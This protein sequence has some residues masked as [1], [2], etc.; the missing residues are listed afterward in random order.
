MQAQLRM[1]GA[2]SSYDF[3]DDT[4]KEIS[5]AQTTPDQPAETPVTE[6]LAMFG[7][8]ILNGIV[9]DEART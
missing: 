3:G 4:K 5:S 8:S 1:K 9:L 7:L 2:C 6:K